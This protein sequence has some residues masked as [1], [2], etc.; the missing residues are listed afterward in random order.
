MNTLKQELE[1]RIKHNLKL[2]EYIK[3]E[4]NRYRIMLQQIEELNKRRK[5]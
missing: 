3:E 1:N 2:Q 4:I 5:K